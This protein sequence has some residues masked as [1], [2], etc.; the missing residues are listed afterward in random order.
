MSDTELNEKAVLE[1]MN[2]MDN[3]SVTN[4]KKV[5]P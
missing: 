1:A 4:L 5:F 3:V 2:E